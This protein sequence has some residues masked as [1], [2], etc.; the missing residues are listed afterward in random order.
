MISRRTLL[1][2]LAGAGIALSLRRSFSPRGTDPV[3]AASPGTIVFSWLANGVPESFASLQQHAGAITHLSPTWYSVK[4]DV[5]ITGGTDSLVVDFAK[6]HGIGLHPLVRNDRFDPAVARAVLATPKRRAKLADR[7]T[8][9]VVNGGFDGV[10]LD[11]EGPFGSSRDAYT[12]LVQRLSTKLA[13]EGK[14]VTVDVVPQLS[15]VNAIPVTSWAAPYDYAGLAAASYAVLLMAYDYSVTLP[16]S[17]SPLWWVQAAITHAQLHIP[18]TKL[19]VSLPFYGR[20]WTQIAGKTTMTALTQIEALNLLAWSGAE[21]QRPAHDATPRF[22]W[23]DGMEKHVVHYEDSQSLS[24]KLQLV[25]ARTV[26]AAFWRLGEE[27][28]EEWS[29]IQRWLTSRVALNPAR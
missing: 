29:A 10:N 4:A 12:D 9:L 14:L 13:S 22:S 19:V 6:S 7:I 11:F 28:A 23:M 20:H 1:H 26:G 27:E 25:D 24:A 17:I 2:R 16:G 18:A 15:D 5:S 8:A 3:E 21:I